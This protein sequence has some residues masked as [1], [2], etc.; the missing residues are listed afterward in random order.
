[1]NLAYDYKEE[2]DQLEEQL[3]H[4]DCLKKPSF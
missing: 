1:M 4:M 2:L 3:S